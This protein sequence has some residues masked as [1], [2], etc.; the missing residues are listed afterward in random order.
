MGSRPV[1][2]VKARRSRPR[3]WLLLARVSNL[4]TVWTNVLAG[5][6]VSGASLDPLL[7]LVAAA[8]LFYTGGM[9][10]NDAF[11]APV[12]ARER[13]E[14]PIPAGDITRSE[15]FAVGATL[16]GAAEATLLLA[17][18][19]ASAM[20]WGAVLAAAI[21]FYDFRH[22]Q[23]A[24]GPVIM[25]LCRA[26]VYVVAAAGAGAL[27]SAVALPAL[28]M[29]SYVIAVTEVAKRAGPR[30]GVVVPLLIAGIA[31]V[32]GVMMVSVGPVW[33]VAAGIAAF[34]LTLALQRV[35]PGT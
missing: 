10:L 32:D 3:A 2:I 29:W 13:P 26:L 6:I 28:L 16:I 18:H 17:P 24:Y 5:L 33:T 12:D 20:A 7:P 30:A 22:Q 1:A 23:Q 4:P 34:V 11:D 14:R 25:G 31:L 15:A 19:P 35:V 8:S 9:F 21:V 27:G